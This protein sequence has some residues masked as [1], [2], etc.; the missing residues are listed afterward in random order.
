MGGE[1]AENNF[2]DLSHIKREI[3]MDVGVMWVENNSFT[4]HFGIY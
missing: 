4:Q 1:W 2:F 3:R